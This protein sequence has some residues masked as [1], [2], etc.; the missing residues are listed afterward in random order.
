MLRRHNARGLR[1][2]ALNALNAEFSKNMG[3][4][5]LCFDRNRL[6]IFLIR[7]HGASVVSNQRLPKIAAVFTQ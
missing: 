1:C 3:E 7:V 4:I 6:S 2:R 5:A